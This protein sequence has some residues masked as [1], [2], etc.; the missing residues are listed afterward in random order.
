ML[1]VLKR[2]TL[3]GLA[4][5]SSFYIDNFEQIFVCWDISHLEAFLFGS[6]LAFGSAKDR[7]LLRLYHRGAPHFYEKQENF[8]KKYLSHFENVE[9][10]MDEYD[11]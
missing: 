11:F 9:T 8:F 3:D 6:S 5:K 10:S 7:N 2:Y 4:K 1:K